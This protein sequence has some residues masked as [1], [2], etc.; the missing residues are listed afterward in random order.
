MTQVLHEPARVTRPAVS[1]ATTH[2]RDSIADIAGKLARREGR[3]DIARDKEILAWCREVALQ[4]VDAPIQAF[5]PLLVEHIV[6]DRIRRERKQRENAGVA[7]DVSAP[8]RSRQ[9]ACS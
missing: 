8:R 5:V 9:S 3:N 2:S 1:S 6:G 4:F 7:T